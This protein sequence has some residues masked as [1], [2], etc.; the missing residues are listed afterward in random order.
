MLF[1]SL[2][3]SPLAKF[4]T[5]DVFANALKL[6]FDNNKF[7]TVLCFE[8]LDDV[9]EPGELFCEIN[10]TLKQDGTLILSVPQM[11][12]IHNAPYD[13]YRYTRYGLKYQAEKHGFRV[14]SITGVGGFWARS[15]AV[16]M[17]FLYKFGVNSLIRK[18]IGFIAAPLQ[19]L[20]SIMDKQFYSENDVIC[21]LLVAKKIS[22]VSIEND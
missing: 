22:A 4:G 10:R 17:R 15:A 9:P 7:D 18:F 16:F 12:N 19:V 6:P 1:R 14:L 20:F 11:W 2:P 5:V 13:Y 3:S 8:V 21:N